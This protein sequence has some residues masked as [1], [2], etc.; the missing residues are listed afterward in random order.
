[1]LSSQPNKKRTRGQQVKRL[2]SPEFLE[3]PGLRG[4]PLGT[5]SSNSRGEKPRC[6]RFLLC[7]YDAQ[8]PWLIA[9]P[10]GN[11]GNFTPTAEG[12]LSAALAQG[13]ELEEGFSGAPQATS[14]I[15]LACLLLLRGT[16]YC[17]TCYASVSLLITL[18]LPCYSGGTSKG[19]DFALFSAP[20]QDSALHIVGAHKISR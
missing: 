13:G 3:L 12:L 7:S 14:S 1:M 11:K 19:E 6:F 5:A 20:C 17:L 8:K 18:C 10:D 4:A 15:P 16:Y 9:P 2:C